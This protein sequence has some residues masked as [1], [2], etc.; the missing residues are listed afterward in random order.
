MW[1]AVAENRYG[2]FVQAAQVVAKKQRRSLR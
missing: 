1:F 2:N